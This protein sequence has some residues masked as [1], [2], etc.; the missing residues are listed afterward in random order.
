[1]IPKTSSARWLAGISFGVAAIAVASLLVVLLTDPSGMTLDGNAPEGTVQRY[2]NALQDERYDEA[3]Q[4]LDA[5]RQAECTS[6]EFSAEFRNT[7]RFRGVQDTRIRLDRV[8]EASDGTE[9]TIELVNFSGI[10]PF[11][12]DFTFED[13]RYKVTYLVIE[14][15]DG[16]R[17]NQ[18]PWPYPGCAYRARL[19][20]PTPTPSPTPAPAAP[21]EATGA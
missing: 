12:L 8:R 6:A 10:E 13:G 1:M 4:L 15:N 19:P 16:W 20:E 11:N 17:V 5:D 14:T 2:I 3:Y 18:A 7:G 21:A 9:V